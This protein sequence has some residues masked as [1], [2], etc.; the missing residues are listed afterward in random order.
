MKKQG[1][2]TEMFDFHLR[3]FDYGVPPHKTRAIEIAEASNDYQQ[4]NRLRKQLIKFQDVES[5]ISA[6]I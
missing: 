2:N 3:V 4:A 5:E 6:Q 1:L